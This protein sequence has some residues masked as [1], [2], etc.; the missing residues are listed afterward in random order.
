MDSELHSSEQSEIVEL[1]SQLEEQRHEIARLRLQLE[2]LQG[3]NE[4][5]QKLG[6]K[7]RKEIQEAKRLNQVLA[8]IVVYDQEKLLQKRNA[9]ALKQVQLSKRLG[10]KSRSYLLKKSLNPS[11]TEWSRQR[12]PAGIGW[13]FDPDAKLFYPID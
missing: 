11:F 7:Y 1:R 3:E 13:R 4:A 5:R 6:A 8:Q 2:N 9:Y 12:D 10:L